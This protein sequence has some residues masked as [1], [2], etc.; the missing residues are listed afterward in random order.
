MTIRPATEHDF[1]AIRTRFCCVIASGDRDV[2]VADTGRDDALVTRR[3]L[4]DIE[5]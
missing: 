5:V 1:D 2:F 3:F 4:D